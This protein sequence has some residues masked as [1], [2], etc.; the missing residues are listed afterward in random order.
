MCLS[1]Q[2][3][4]VLSTLSPQM[5][6]PS[7]RSGQEKKK[8]VQG[9]FHREALGSQ[10]EPRTKCRFHLTM[11]MASWVLWKCFFFQSP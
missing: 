8:K 2:G 3:E 7:T 10:P 5:L 4:D 9:G 11:T 1:L 6:C